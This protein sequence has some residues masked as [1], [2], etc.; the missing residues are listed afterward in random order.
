MVADRGLLN[1]EKIERLITDKKAL[2]KQN[3]HSDSE[4]ALSQ[5]N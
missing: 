4:A 5:F 2:E 3:G 1:T